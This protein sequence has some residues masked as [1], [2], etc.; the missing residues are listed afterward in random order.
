MGDLALLLKR[1]IEHRVDFVI[2]GGF[3]AATHG[4]TLITRDLDVACRFSTANL[5]RLQDAVK[6]LHPVHRMTPQRLPLCLTPETIPGLKNI[7]VDTDWG[8]LDCLS[9]V[10]GIGDFAAVKKKSEIINPGLGPC[11]ILKIDALIKAKK[12]MGRDRD[13]A[14]VLQLRAIQERQK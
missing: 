2:V 1:L 13:R 9:S 6:D 3:A 14:A 7:Y 12:A 11:R 5:L 8:S 10:L 4:V